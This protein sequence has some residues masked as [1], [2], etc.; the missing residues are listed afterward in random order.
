MKTL[1]A[2][3]IDAEH[4]GVIEHALRMTRGPGGE[5]R[6]IIGPPGAD[7]GD[8]FIPPSVEFEVRGDTVSQPFMTFDAG[9]M[10]AVE[11]PALATKEDIVA[12]QNDMY[13]VA[14]KVMRALCKD[15]PLAGFPPEILAALDE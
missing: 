15:D 13:R 10:L 7:H 3:L 11:G 2:Y 12:A 14:I 5:V 4:K 9:E 8:E 6:L 1:E